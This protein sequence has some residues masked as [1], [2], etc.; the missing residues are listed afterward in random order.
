MTMLDSLRKRIF[1]LE[2]TISRLSLE[3]IECIHA[4]AEDLAKEDN[5]RGQ[6][7]ICISR[8]VAKLDKL[9][10]WCLPFV[11]KGGIFLAMKGPN[12]TDE[13]E[14]AKPV[15]QKMGAKVMEVRLV[16]ILPGMVHSVV[17]V[18]KA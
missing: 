11:K 4:R 6:Y 5:H 18:G 12:V 13:L 3:D 15:I 8:A 1:F 7:D 14:A 17:V 9:C 2:D 16:E 10:G